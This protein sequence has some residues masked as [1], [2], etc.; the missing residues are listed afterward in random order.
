MFKKMKKGLLVGM[1]VSLAVFVLPVAVAAKGGQPPAQAP[2]T[3][4][5]TAVT[6]GSGLQGAQRGGWLTGGVSMVDAVAEAAGMTR[7]E[8]IAEL[9]SG[10]S[11]A[12]VADPDDVVAVLTRVRAEALAQAVAEG[13]FTQAQ[14]DDML[15]QMQ[16]D[17][18]EE[19][20]QPWTAQGSGNGSGYDGTQPA[21][22]SGYRGGN[23]NSTSRG[24]G[25]PDRP[26]SGTGECTL[27]TP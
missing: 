4:A 7:A 3:N 5:T 19:L 9:Q 16:A 23:N 15:A 27:V 22:G 21:D 14:A 2:R 13:R 24:A 8:V 17:W 11:F 10:A 1:V 18:L 26:M 12:S 6:T 25:R 20:Q